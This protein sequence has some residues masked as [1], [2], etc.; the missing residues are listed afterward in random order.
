MSYLNIVEELFLGNIELQR[1]QEFSQDDGFRKFFSKIG[2][3]FGLIDSLKDS[4]N[5]GLIELGSISGTIKINPIFAIDKDGLFIVKDTQDNFQLPNDN[6]WYWIKISQQYSIEE[7]GIVSIDNFGLLSGVDTEFLKI[8]R[9]QPDFPTK[10][11]FTN[12]SNNLLEYEVLEIIDDNNAY[13]QGVFI[14]ETD[15]TFAMV[16]TFTEGYIPPT[17]NK[18]PFK[19]DNCLGQLILSN[20]MPS[21]TLG[22][23]FFLAKVKRNGTLVYIEDQRS[24]FRFKLQSDYYLN[25][26]PLKQNPLIGIEEIKWD[27]RTSTKENNL[28]YLAWGLRINNY[29]FNSNLNKLTITNGVGGRF[30]NTTFSSN[31]NDGDFDGWRVYSSQSDIYFKILSSTKVT[32]TIELILMNSD[33]S[34]LSGTDELIIVPPAE[35]IEIICVADID[36][37]TDLPNKNFIFPINERVGKI[38]LLVD[39]NNY[40]YNIRYRYKSHNVYSEIYDLLDDSVGYFAEDQHYDDG[41]LIPSPTPTPY[42]VL[43]MPTGFIPLKLN[44]SAYQLFFLGD[45]PGLDIFPLLNSTTQIDLKVGSSKENLSIIA[46]TPLTL[47][48]D[49]IINLKSDPFTK[50]GNHFNIN[51][52]GNINLGS[53]AIY[54]RENYISSLI[55]GTLIKTIGSQNQLNYRQS[56]IQDLL[57]IRCMFNGFAWTIINEDDFLRTYQNYLSINQNILDIALKANSSQLNRISSQIIINNYIGNT[58]LSVVALPALGKTSSKTKVH[59]Q[60]W[61][62]SDNGGAIYYDAINFILKINSTTQKLI[63]QTVQRISA[64][65]VIDLMWVGLVSN[66]D[67]LSIYAKTESVTPAMSNI[68]IQDAILTADQL[69][70]V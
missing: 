52:F 44:S 46:L 10:I 21:Y 64:H 49:L 54:I 50:N 60:I 22:K 37:G 59:A 65:Y 13:L 7:K 25:Q 38:N 18:F 8:F 3:E 31:F 14:G 45:I 6:N 48:Q 63:K 29:T 66:T 57:W 5:N 33:S 39:S 36:Y 1:L 30:K 53:F 70:G 16:G 56:P 47:T 40:Y 42:V 35:E 20:S 12:S 26:L 23:E 58:E 51:L 43:P 27:S 19:Y 68:T 61:Y 4:F 62:Q 41:N 28:L 34:L 15:L 9:G 32:T 11:K 2:T 55:P 67:I 17:L 69:D 24:Q